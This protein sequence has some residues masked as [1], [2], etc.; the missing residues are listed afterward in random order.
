MPDVSRKD[1]LGVVFYENKLKLIEVD[2]STRNQFRINKIT[3]SKLDFPFNVESIV[4]GKYIAEHAN[5]LRSLVDKFG[6]TD[7]RA[8]FS[9]ENDLVIIKKYPYDPDFTDEEIVDQIDWEVKKFSYSKD[10]GYIIDFQKIK[11]YK[12]RSGNE[13][14]VVAVR[15][16]II[17][18]I[19]QVFKKARIKLTIV[20]TNIFAAIRAINKNYECREG[21]L[22][23]LICVEKKAIQFI[24]VDS[25]AF[26]SLHRVTLKLKSDISDVVV[27]EDIIKIISTELK[28]IVIDNKIGEKIEDLTRIFLYGDMV[29]DDV[30]ESLQNTFN[31]RIDRAN[32]FRKLRF[33]QNVSV[34]EYIWSRPE[35]FTVC[36]GTA[37]R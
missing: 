34:D 21:E 20:D 23:A 7:R 9:L 10:D 5:K 24:I 17:N 26:F 27:S 18:Y 36:V 30:L 8:A 14:I 25:G 4:D 3:E 28:R 1:L 16:N 6:F 31:V 12:S 32:P 22:C 2:S 15:E 37:L 33:A 13:M 35:T 11:P 29:Q 19:K